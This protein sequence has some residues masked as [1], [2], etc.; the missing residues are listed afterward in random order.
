MTVRELE[1]AL[2]SIKDKGQGVRYR[3]LDGVMLHLEP[4][5]FVNEKGERLFR[6]DTNT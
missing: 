2:N 5:L 6:E 3:F 1:H 4:E